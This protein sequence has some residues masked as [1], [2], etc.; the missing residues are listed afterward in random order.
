MAHRSDIL[1]LTTVL[2]L[3]CK[4]ESDE[5]LTI[6]FFETE[7]NTVYLSSLLSKGYE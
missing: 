7:Y 1:L 5:Y 4:Y 3:V 2:K 6:D